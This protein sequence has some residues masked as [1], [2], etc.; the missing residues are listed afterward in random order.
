VCQAWWG[1]DDWTTIIRQPRRERQ[2]E[3]R[4][5]FQTELGY[6]FS[7]SLPIYGVEDR[8]TRIMYY[9]IHATD[10]PEAPKLMKRAYLKSVWRDSFE[11]LPM[12][13]LQEA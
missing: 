12:Y 10:H 9:M 3:L 8:K 11:Q 13:P 2:E 4:K 1:R 7:N 5:R 6:R